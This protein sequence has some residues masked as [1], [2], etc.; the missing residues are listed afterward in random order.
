MKRFSYLAIIAG[1]FFATSIQAAVIVAS[2][3]GFVTIAGGSAKGDGTV[4]PLAKYNYSVGRELHYG[5]GFLFSPLVAMDRRNYFVFDLS[6]ISDPISSATLT[7][8]SGELETADA[9]ESYGIFG[10]TDPGLALGLAT[11]LGGATMMSAFDDAGDPLVADA[12]TLYSKLADGPVFFGGIVLTKVVDDFK[13]IDIALTP[14]G[15]GYLNA[16]LGSTVILGGKVTSVVGAPSPQQPFGGTGPDSF[17][18]AKTPTL[19][20]TTVPE[21]SAAL[22]FIG[23]LALAAARRRRA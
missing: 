6:G 15:L 20:V 18:G 5:A 11:G 12:A 7:L 3:A 9:T 17:P 19:T 14:G 10:S 4:T 2:D 1:C 23:M 16:H 22:L 21:P 8:W 13:F